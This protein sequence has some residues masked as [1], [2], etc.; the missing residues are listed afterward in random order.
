MLGVLSVSAILS[1]TASRLAEEFIFWSSYEFRTLTLHDGFAMGSSMMSQK[2]NP[3]T[4]EVIRGYISLLIHAGQP[5]IA[6][7]LADNAD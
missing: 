2:K 4:V 1:T 6:V 7:W 3:G 5:T